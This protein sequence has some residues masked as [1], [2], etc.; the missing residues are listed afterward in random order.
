MGQATGMTRKLLVVAAAALSFGA[1]LC[2]LESAGET[3]PAAILRGR[4][5][6]VALWTGDTMVVYGGFVAPKAGTNTGAVYTLATDSWSPIST[7]DAPPRAC[8]PSAVWAGSEMIAWGGWGTDAECGGNGFV[9]ATRLGG[10]YDPAGDHWAGI[11]SGWLAGQEGRAGHTMVWTGTQMLVWGGY[12]KY[13]T[14]PGTGGL[15]YSPGLNSWQFLSAT[16]APSTRTGHT[17]V[18]TGSEMIVWGGHGN[19][20]NQ[21]TDPIGYLRTGG[22]YNPATDTWVALPT[23]GA[24]SPRMSHSAVWTGREMIVWGGAGPSG[25][26]GSGAKYDP[27]TGL[28]TPLSTTGA[29]DA[30]RYHTAVWTG[31]RM[32]VWGGSPG[33]LSLNTG[34]AYDPDRN[35]WTRL[36][37][38][39]APVGREFH[40]A[41][42]TGQAM[43]VWGGRR[44]NGGTY[45]YLNTGGRYVP[46]TNS[47]TP[48]ATPALDPLSP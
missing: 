3:T 11:S 22:R 32:L 25:P 28:W 34:G 38:A 48:I 10:R 17:A 40:A 47:W 39:N 45:S 8:P 16:G 13:E 44:R 14:A 2:P 24:P 41:I 9:C 5:H 20:S 36:S 46:S 4:S 31:S 15:R 27:L 21:G 30:R 7:Q 26:L 1:A 37:T 35:A 42:W 12:Q 6:H 19:S 18:W 23:L 33:D 43:L 29:P